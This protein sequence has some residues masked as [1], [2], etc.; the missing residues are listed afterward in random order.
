MFLHYKN[1]EQLFLFVLTASWVSCIFGFLLKEKLNIPFK[2]GDGKKVDSQNKATIPAK[3]GKTPDQPP[4]HQKH[5]PSAEDSTTEQHQHS[6][7]ETNNDL[8]IEQP[9]VDST[10]IIDPTK[11]K[12]GQLVSFNFNNENYKFEMMSCATK[13]TGNNPNWYVIYHHPETEKD[14][15]GSI[16]FRQVENLKFENSTEKTIHEVSNINYN[17]AKLAELKT[18]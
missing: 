3:T 9:N 8:N 4:T 11:F 17:D 7:V 10:S 6:N 13:A 1:C 14:K 16:R 5:T 18:K 12:K 15:S 2:F